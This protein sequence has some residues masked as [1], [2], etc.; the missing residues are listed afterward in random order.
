MVGG[1]VRRHAAPMSATP[2]PP[3][4]PERPDPPQPDPAEQPTQA[5]GA[6]P[7]RFLRSRTDRV[8]AG[9]AGGLGRYFG[10]DPVLV[11]IAIVVLTFFGGAGALLYLAVILLVPNEGESGAEPGAPAPERNRT[12]VIVGLVA[13]VLLAGPLLFAP[14]IFAGGILVP[15]AFLALAGLAVGWLVTGRR[16]ERAAGALVRTSL[17]GLGVLVLCGVLAAASF[18]SAGLGGEAVVAG[19][20]IAAGIAV[21]AAAFV[22]P[23]RWLVLPAL[24]LAIPAAFV[25][26]AGISLDGGV[27]DRTYRPGAVS[28]IADRYEIGAGRLVVDLRGVELPSGRHALDVEVGMGEI[29]VE[30]VDG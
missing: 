30:R 18:W 10:V 3:D 28:E 12:V 5:G 4:P 14:A 9:V 1:P 16:P 22:R 17:L 11:R 13:L 2:P 6:P 23:V 29:D 15:L 8:L 26:A 21:L 27:G 7:R 20:V 19:V 24:A 25:S